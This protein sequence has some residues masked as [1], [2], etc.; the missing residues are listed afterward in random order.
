MSVGVLASR[1]L[2]TVGALSKTRWGWEEG[3][4]HRAAVR[5]VGMESKRPVTHTRVGG[6]VPTQ[7]EAIALIR[8]AGGKVERI[9][10]E[11]H[12]PGGISTHTTPHINYTTKG[13]TKATVVIQPE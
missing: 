1:R 6:V 8:A 9:D 3:A 2:G 5:Q 12:A 4:K 7:D 10:I 13:G 11:G